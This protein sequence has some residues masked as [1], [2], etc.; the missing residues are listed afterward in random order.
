M[1]EEELLYDEGYNNWKR[2][3]RVLIQPEPRKFLTFEA[4]LK[5]HAAKE[6]FHGANPIDLREKFADSGLQII[7]KLANI[8]LTPDDSS[9]DGGSWH[10]EGALNE[11]IC[12][13]A[14]YYYDEENITDSHLEFRQAIDKEAMT[15]MPPQVKLRILLS[16]LLPIA[17]R[18]TRKIA[19]VR[20]TRR[21]VR[22]RTRRKYN[23]TTW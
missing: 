13:T 16:I 9:Y 23:S 18:L 15:M 20:I 5:K 4:F 7:F 11:H 21:N 17:L 1:D 22:H 10:V 8:H 6:D 12:A 2:Q 19:R 14:L 3:N